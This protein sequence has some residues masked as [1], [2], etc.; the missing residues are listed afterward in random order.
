MYTNIAPI[1]RFLQGGTVAETPSSSGQGVPVSVRFDCQG[2]K[3]R[4]VSVVVGLPLDISP[5]IQ[6]EEY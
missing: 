5:N 4:W 3:N 2:P 1:Y 6:R